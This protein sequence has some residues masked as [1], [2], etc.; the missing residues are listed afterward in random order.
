M[1]MRLVVGAVALL[2][3]GCTGSG[4]G[5]DSVAVVTKEYGQCFINTKASPRF[6]GKKVT[7]RCEKN[8]VLLGEPYEKE[9]VDYIES[10]HLYKKSGKYRIKDREEL[11]FVESLHSVCQIKPVKGEGDQKI[12]RVYFDMKLKECRPFEWSGKGGIVPFKNID[13]CEQHC[14]YGG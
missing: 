13:E 9:G 3:G 7:F 12:R 5:S 4:L 10:A 6:N 2:L 8:R 11:H 1:M 14:K